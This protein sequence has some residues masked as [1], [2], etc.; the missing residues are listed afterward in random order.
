[1]FRAIP[2]FAIVLIMKL[3][4]DLSIKVIPGFLTFLPQPDRSPGAR[5]PTLH[6]P[7]RVDGQGGWR[8][9]VVRAAEVIDDDGTEKRYELADGVLTKMNPPTFRHML[10]AKFIEMPG[11]L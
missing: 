6:H 3:H 2:N 1:M 8:G 4:A 11:R 5:N 10:I 7:T 9:G